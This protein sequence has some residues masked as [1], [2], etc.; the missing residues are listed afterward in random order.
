ML[1]KIQ[2]QINA[3]LHI[4]SRYSGAASREM[5][6][7]K[8]ADGARR[9]G[10]QLISMGDC[11]HL[12]R[13][14]EL[15]ECSRIDDGTWEFMGVKFIL[16]TEVEDI[17]RVHHLL[18]FPCLSA[19]MDFRE[20]IMPHSKNLE[21]DGRPKIKLGGE[22]LT[23]FA[24]DVDALIGPAHAFT[25]WTAM[26]AYHNTL[27]SCYGDLLDHISFL[28]LGL[29]AD[30]DYADRISELSKLT[31]LTNSDAHSPQPA[32]LGREFNRFEV[33]DISFSELKKALLSTGGRKCV[34][35]VGLPPAEGKYNESACIKCHLHYS[36]P[37][38][39]TRNWT[40]QCGGR[41]K[42]GVKDR[43]EEIADNPQPMHPKGRPPYLHM[44]PLA[45]I[46]A[47][48]LGSVSSFSPRILR[49]WKLLVDR[50]GSEANLL[51]DTPIN[52]IA[53]VV[54]VAVAEAIEAFRLGKILI[55][56]GG[57][58]EYGK[59]E[60]SQE[61]H[62]VS[63]KCAEGQRNLQEFEIEKAKLK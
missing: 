10:V 34:L 19:I 23:Q 56:P 40:C 39:R 45:E 17:N 44:I 55:R 16:G 36:L 57:G 11:L 63:F 41:I 12:K 49:E 43:V 48:A 24:T 31:F 53:R 28:E 60:L 2:M 47:A 62:P 8:I 54:P 61:A 26:Y 46:I 1:V 42:K 14:G 5:V 4:H 50:F 35:N 37:E 29:S 32:R 7:P 6:I 15:K 52:E 13:L 38:A 30:S 3:D 9:K 20:R 27:K 22:D 21:M 25:P 51:V 58:G 59:I 33:E 18:F